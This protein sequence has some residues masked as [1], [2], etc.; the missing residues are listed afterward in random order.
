MFDQ[1][2]IVYPFRHPPLG[3]DVLW[4]CEGKRYSVVIDPEREL[5]GSTP[6]RVEMTWYV[7][8]KRTPK[9]AW[10]GSTFVRLDARKRFACETEKEAI[11]SYIA[12]KRRQVNILSSQLE[13]AERGLAIA[14]ASLE[15]AL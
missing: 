10:L 11:E 14:Q 7:V 13:E 5:Y 4:R 12:R 3:E 1:S 15:A 6:L 8:T 2:K 9:G